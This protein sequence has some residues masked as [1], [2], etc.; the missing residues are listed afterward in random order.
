MIV[1]ILRQQ[2]GASGGPSLA[3]SDPSEAARVASLLGA[4]LG[5][6]QM[7][8]PY[9]KAAMREYGLLGDRAAYIAILATVRV[10]VGYTFLPIPEW[11]SGWEYEGRA[12]LG[13]V[14]YGDG[15]RFKGRGYVQLTG[16]ANYKSAGDALGLPLLTNPDLAL[17]PEH[18]A[19]ILLWYFFQ[20]DIASMARR[21]DWAAVRRAVNGGYNG[22]DDFIGYVYALDGGL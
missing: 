15:A 17:E 22:W 21:G 19:R 5:G 12:D 4:D 9:I 8:L 11:A 14:W 20:R 3:L 16:R 2:Q 18:A 7:S 6:L 1:P 10:E 13:N